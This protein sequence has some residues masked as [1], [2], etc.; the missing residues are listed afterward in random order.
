MP[1]PETRSPGGTYHAN[2]L[3]V[4]SLVDYGAVSA[5]GLTRFHVTPFQTVRAV[6]PHTA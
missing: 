2:Y 4:A 3:F 1:P 5:R 6:F